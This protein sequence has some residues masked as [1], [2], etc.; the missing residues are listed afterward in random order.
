MGYFTFIKCTKFSRMNRIHCTQT[1][2]WY[3]GF[4]PIQDGSFWGCS[5][6]GRAR[7]SPVPKTCHTYPTMMTL[8]IVIP[9]LQN[10][11]VFPNKGYGVIISLHDVINRILLHDSNCI[12]D[13]VIWPKFCNSSISMREVIITSIL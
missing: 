4:N 5:R 10:V 1:Q 12:L 3:D 8:G 11:N 7:M 2:I 6:M 9:Y 13:V